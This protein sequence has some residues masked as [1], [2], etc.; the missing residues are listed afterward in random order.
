MQLYKQTMLS[1]QQHQMQMQLQKTNPYSNLT[2]YANEAFLSPLP[3]NA[4]IPNFM[5]MSQMAPQLNMPNM[6]IDMT[7]SPQTMFGDPN[8]PVNLMFHGQI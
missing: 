6:P 1:R 7:Y 2:G 4:P 8:L 5:D 3:T